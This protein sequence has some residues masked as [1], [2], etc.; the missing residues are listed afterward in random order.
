[1]GK[2]HLVQK[3]RVSPKNNRGKSTKGHRKQLW[4]IWDNCYVKYFIVKIKRFFEV[5]QYLSYKYKRKKNPVKLA[6]YWLL[7]KPSLF[8]KRVKDD[9][10]LKH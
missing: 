8:V 3:V 2:E 7:K 9:R 4:P 6:K 1:M 5:L 10:C